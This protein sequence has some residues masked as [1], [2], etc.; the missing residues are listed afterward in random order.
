[1][2]FRQWAVVVL[3]FAA[4]LGASVWIARSAFPAGDIPVALPWWAHA[5]AAA[6]LC[7]EILFRALKVSLSGRALHIP[8]NFT[9]ALRMSLGGDFGAAITPS[10]SG[11]EPARFLVLAESGMKPA[12]ALIILF[13]ELVLETVS[14]AI[15]ALMLLATFGAEGR[16]PAS[17]AGLIGG[18]ALAVLGVGLAGYLLSRTYSSGPPP[19][20][21]RTLRLHAGR[22]RAIQRALRSLRSGVGALRQAQW[23]WLVGSL[24]ASVLH[25]VVRLAVLPVVV[26]GIGGAAVALQSLDRIV[27]WPLVLLY[28]GAAAPAPAGGGL[29]ELAFR[30]ALGS[31]IPDQFF[32]ASLL[33]WRA[34]TFYAYIP[35]GALAAGATVLRAM[36]GRNA[37]PA[38]PTELAAR[39]TT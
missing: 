1:M 3:S 35:L 21:A 4:A 2:N 6:A 10:R 30:A 32:G 31:A 7:A 12:S 16:A 24:V 20:W 39:N 14:L 36:R 25:I 5:L 8:L 38:S 9:L 34:Y 19:A 17:I 13:S 23:R 29:I 27:L 11:A 26:W 22:W 15:V 28:G 18:Y 37:E 33:W